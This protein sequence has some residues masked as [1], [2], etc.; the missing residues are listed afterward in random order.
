MSDPLALRLI[1]M[2]VGA[3]SSLLNAAGTMLIFFILV[4]VNVDVF[5]RFLFNRPLT[6]TTEMVI[7]ATTAVVYFQFAHALRAGRIVRIDGAVQLLSRHAPTAAHLVQ[8]FFALVGAVTMAF[9]VHHAIPFLERAYASGDLYGN[10][11]VFG[12]PKWPVRLVMVVGCSIAVAQFL[13]LAARDVLQ[14]V[15]L[16]RGGATR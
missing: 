5:G 9:L 11:M 7:V 13:V 12:V 10:P 4:V 2:V 8:A 1:D 14:A 3:L 6:G 15:A 16:L